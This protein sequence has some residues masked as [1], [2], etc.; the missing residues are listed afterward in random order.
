MNS[1][2]LLVALLVALV[3]SG[4]VTLFI[5]RKLAGRPA[6]ATHFQQYVAAKRALQ[7][8]EVVK[9]EDLTITEWPVTKPLTGAFTKASDV[10]GRAVMYPIAGSQPVLQEYLAAP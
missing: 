4:A 10:A 8:G 3:L 7:P 5:S 1:R 9:A 2:R 6:A